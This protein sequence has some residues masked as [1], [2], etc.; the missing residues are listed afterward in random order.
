[1]NGE[2]K[3]C[4]ICNCD[5]GIDEYDDYT[6]SEKNNIFCNECA[7]EYLHTCD[8]CNKQKEE[9][10]E[11]VFAQFEHYEYDLYDLQYWCSECVKKYASAIEKAYVSY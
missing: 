10:L 9:D 2:N 6:I 1:M 4:S 7:E 5:V 8:R 11:K 3:K